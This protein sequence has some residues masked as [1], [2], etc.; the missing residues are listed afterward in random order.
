[1]F[2]NKNFRKVL[3]KKTILLCPLN[4]GSHIA[5]FECFETKQQ[6]S[7]YER[8]SEKKDGYFKHCGKKL[9]DVIFY[10]PKWAKF[11]LFCIFLPN[12]DRKHPLKQKFVPGSY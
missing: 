6:W 9:A 10:P 2:E 3:V 8:L 12:L 5:I 1:M 7:K 11:A 4:Q